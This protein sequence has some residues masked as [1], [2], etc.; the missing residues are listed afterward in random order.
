MN[1]TLMQSKSKPGHQDWYAARP[2]IRFTEL[3]GPRLVGASDMRIPSLNRA[4]F[5][6]WLLSLSGGWSG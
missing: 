3:C 4:N 2:S 6:T 1:T 5:H